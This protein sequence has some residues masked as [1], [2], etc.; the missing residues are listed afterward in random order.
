MRK[1]IAPL[2]L[3]AALPVSAHSGHAEQTISFM[4]G[5]IHPLKGLD[6][7]L[8]MF[9]VGM[10]SATTTRRIWLAPASFAATLLTGA[11]LAQSG[12]ALPAV[13]PIV[14][15]SVFLLGLLVMTRSHLPEAAT[16]ALV[17]GFALFHGAAHGQELSTPIALA[18][19]VLATALLHCL[20]I[21][22][23]LLLKSRSPW[24]QRIAGG[25]IALAGTGFGA[26]LMSCILQ[27]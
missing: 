19:M 6:H 26:G 5:F 25:G 9:A 2:F 20:G 17:G 15:A 18:G 27:D 11:L 24:W 13:E 14:A 4:G 16:A 8:A 23:G 3:F 12:L 7:M 10:W 22:V 1:F 21:A